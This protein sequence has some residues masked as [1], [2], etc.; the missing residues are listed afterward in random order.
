MSRTAGYGRENE[1]RCQQL[2]YQRYVEVFFHSSH[3]SD[4]SSSKA[5]PYALAQSHRSEDHDA[6]PY[7]VSKSLYSITDGRWKIKFEPFY[8]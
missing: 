6:Q 2:A 7:V 3:S 8:L 4:D 5:A 1:Q